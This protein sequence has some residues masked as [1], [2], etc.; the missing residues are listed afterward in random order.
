LSRPLKRGEIVLMDHLPVHKDA[1][2]AEAIEAAGET[3]IYLPKYSPDLNPIELA[4][5]KAG[6]MAFLS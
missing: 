3:L 1:G 6:A 5:S 2:V 4:F